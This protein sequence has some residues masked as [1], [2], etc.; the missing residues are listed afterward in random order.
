MKHASL[1]F[2]IFTGEGNSSMSPALSDVGIA[3]A[4][5]GLVVLGL[6]R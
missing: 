2:T 5:R 4:L 6:M 3:V 1:E